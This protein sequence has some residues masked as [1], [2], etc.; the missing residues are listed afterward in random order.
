MNN[1]SIIIY[2]VF[3]LNRVLQL[4][5]TQQS[6]YNIQ[7]SFKIHSLIKWLNETEEFVFDRIRTVF[8]DST[9]NIENPLHQALLSSSVPFVETTLTI[10]ELLQTEGEVKLNVEDVSILEKMLLKTES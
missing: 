5:L 8:G 6:S 9:I 4:L 3:E 1:K 2:D 10:S 7:T